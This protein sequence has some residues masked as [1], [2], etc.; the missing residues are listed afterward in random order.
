[1]PK[2]ID[3]FET[4][5]TNLYIEWNLPSSFPQLLS[6][7]D[8]LGK[9][10][11]IDDQLLSPDSVSRDRQLVAIKQF[12]E[13]F[14]GQRFTDRQIQLQTGNTWTQTRNYRKE[15]IIEHTKDITL[16]KQRH[17]FDISLQSLENNFLGGYENNGKL[18]GETSDELIKTGGPVHIRLHQKGG[19]LNE[20]LGLLSL[21]K[22]SAQNYVANKIDQWLLGVNNFI[23]N[24]RARVG[25]GT[26]V[27]RPEIEY[28]YLE[29][30]YTDNKG[31]VTNYNLTH[32]HVY[33]GAIENTKTY[34]DYFQNSQGF[35]NIRSVRLSDFNKNR[36]DL[37]NLFDGYISIADTF[38]KNLL[39]TKVPFGLGFIIDDFLPDL[40]ELNAIRNAS[41]FLNDIDDVIENLT[42]FYDFQST[43]Y[44]PVNL[45]DIYEGKGTGTNLKAQRIFGKR[46]RLKIDNKYK[47]ARN[48]VNEYRNQVAN[49]LGRGKKLSIGSGVDGIIIPDVNGVVVDSDT[50]LPRAQYLTPGYKD[51]INIGNI[52]SK[53]TDFVDSI[54]VLFKTKDKVVRFRA[55]IEDISENI[56]PSYNENKYLGR[57]ETFYTYN[58]VIRDLSFKLTLQAFSKKEITGVVQRMSYLTTLAYPENT[59]NY[60]TPNIFQVTIG[61]TYKEQPCLVQSITHTI[62]NDASWDVD[63]QY[64]MRIVANV[65][66]RL[67][68]KKIYSVNDETI[69]AGV[70]TLN[71]RFAQITPPVLNTSFLP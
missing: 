43:Q 12:E 67:L 41:R 49:Y 34:Q 11:I 55:L 27:D 6:V 52:Y 23:S 5:K 14:R 7:S 38:I 56:T 42:D 16:H 63:D 60:L 18:Q 65:K 70:P 3:L 31:L 68:D 32:G 45:K 54:D 66:L 28:G 10:K 8:S 71:E 22:I 24:L 50:F 1:M 21:G 30:I 33:F 57:Y 53:N 35:A 25:D 29:K 61:R 51:L 26:I 48:N 2:L 17:G 39:Q 36:F 44:D 58:K 15:N 13:T 47:Q 40:K 9:D 64:P 46:I 69:Y 37:S 19:M 62:E 20:K 4:K 59:G